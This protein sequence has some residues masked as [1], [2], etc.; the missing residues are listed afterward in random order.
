[1]KQNALCYETL[2]LLKQAVR[3][4][5]NEINDDISDEEGCSL[6]YTDRDTMVGSLPSMPSGGNEIACD[7]S[8]SAVK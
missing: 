7:T 8:E 3:L 1:M 6:D 4:I 5:S 2:T